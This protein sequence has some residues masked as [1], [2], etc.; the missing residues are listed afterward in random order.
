MQIAT[1]ERLILRELEERDAP[2]I[3]ELLNEPAWIRFIGNRGIKNVD[4]ARGYIV[5]GP[6]AMYANKGFGLW[7]VERASD[8]MPLGICGLIKRDSL[9]DVDIGFAFLERF[10]GKGYASE[11]GEATMAI[12]REHFALKRIVGITSPD[13]VAS[14]TLLEK[15][16]LTREKVVKL[17]DGHDETVVFGWNAA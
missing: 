4:D 16:G 11:A 3:M 5:K 17:D 10:W 1:T 15:L 6:V 12:G 2:F 8:L 7:L 9:E 13:N 14:I